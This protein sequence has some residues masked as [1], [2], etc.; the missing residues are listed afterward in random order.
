MKNT[1]KNCLKMHKSKNK[2]FEDMEKIVC[3]DIAAG[4]NCLSWKSFHPPPPKKDIALPLGN[5]SMLVYSP[6][7]RIFA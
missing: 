1:E 4:K 5:L 7:M 6:I 3:T 2:L